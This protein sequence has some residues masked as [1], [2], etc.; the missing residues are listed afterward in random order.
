MRTSRDRFGVL[1]LTQTHQALSNRLTVIAMEDRHGMT[2]T[3][4]SRCN[5][6]PSHG[7]EK[8]TSACLWHPY[9]TMVA[10]VPSVEHQHIH[11]TPLAISHTSCHWCAILLGSQHPTGNTRQIGQQ[12]LNINGTAQYLL[13][14]WCV[15]PW[16]AAD[17]MTPVAMANS[18]WKL[19]PFQVTLLIPGRCV[20]KAH[21]PLHD[22]ACSGVPV[23][24]CLICAATL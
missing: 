24:V 9:V 18:D 12:Y 21:G 11:L 1:I 3:C 8:M 10:C 6:L 22:E 19:R 16:G 14:M 20:Q 17:V 2:C 13:A 7:L 23:I 4:I 5:K 15:L